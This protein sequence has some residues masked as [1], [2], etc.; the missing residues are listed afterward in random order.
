MWAHAWTLRRLARDHAWPL[1]APEIAFPKGGAFSSIAPVHDA[2]SLPLQ[3]VVGLVAAYNAG[4]LFHLVLGCVG[5]WALAIACRLSA[6]AALVAGTVFGLN[7][8][9]LSYGVASAVVE[10]ATGGWIAL[11]FAAVIALARAPSAA[12]AVACG[13]AFAVMGLANLYWAVMA[14]LF[15]PL[16]AL[17]VL[18][19]RRRDGEPPLVR[20][21]ALWIPVSIAIAAVLYVPAIRALLGTY[22]GLLEGYDE[23]KQELLHAGVMAKLGH[24]Y[25]TLVGY[26]RPGKGTAAVHHGLDVLIQTTYAGWVAL[27]LAW[28]GYG[29]G[30]RRWALVGGVAMLLSFGPFLFLAPD[31]YR[32]TVVPWWDWLRAGL[33]PTRMITSYVRFSVVTFMALA[34]LAA[35]GV[36]RLVQRG[37]H[38]IVG[39]LVSLFVVG[40]L[41]R[42]SPVPLPIPSAEARI[43]QVSRELATLPGE[44]AVI[45]WPQRYAG[46]DTEV[47]RYFFYQSAHWRPIPYDFAP[48]SYLP[49]AIEG[50]PFFA[51]LERVTYGPEYESDAWTEL[52]DAPPESGVSVLRAMGF[53]YVALHPSF[54]DPARLADVRALLDAHLA[55]VWEGADGSGIWGI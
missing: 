33:P 26:L 18:W 42:F 32:E 48:T 45:E 55:K 41:W 15:S 37:A 46:R 34:V 9:A 36:E 1:D 16:L 17:A 20:G 50:N 4:V 43:P 13:A 5:G 52:S 28:V 35:A 21:H 39:P 40:E 14:A 27:A 47:S 54:V 6:P 8:F 3:P 22:G 25:G 51:A 7:A 44:G 19:E 31:S 23:R 49:G 11:F 10:T 12:R 30:V 24:D 38:W 53:A 2:L 29:R